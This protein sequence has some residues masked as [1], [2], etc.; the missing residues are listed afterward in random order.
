MGGGATGDRIF[1]ADDDRGLLRL[2]ARALEREG[3]ATATAVSGQQALAWLTQNQARLM[4]LD[5]KLPDVEGRELIAR[6]QAAGR[7]PAFI[8][9]TG[10]GD[11]RVAVEMMKRGALDYL[12]KDV[13]FLQFVP[14]VVKRALEQLD[15]E[16]RLAEAEEQVHLVRSVVDQGFSAVLITDAELPDPR[17]VY[18]N[19]TFAQVTGYA[20]ANVIG[21]RL[22]TLAGLTGVQEWL[23]AGLPEG[24]RFL[25]MVS[26][27]QTNAGE[28]WGEWRLGPV[29]DKSGKNAHWLIIFRDIT[30][31]KRLEKELLEISDREQQRI[32]QDL[33][34]GL[35]QHLAGIE[36]MSQVLEQ[37]L[38]RKSKADAVRAGEIG[39]L[40][41][42]AISQTRQVARGLS[43]VNLESGGLKSAL[44][45]LAANTEKRFGV[46]C[47]FVWQPLV[48]V[49]NPASATHLYR[50]AQ[51]AVSNALRHGKASRIRIELKAA[52]ENL[53]LS[54]CDNGKG[55][56]KALPPH[57]GMGLRIMQYRASLMGGSLRLQPEPGGGTGV[58]CSIPLEPGGTADTGT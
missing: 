56:P 25:E 57:K 23:R 27:Y 7:C 34:D 1:I 14:A 13:D 36:L 53:W 9:I 58:V 43:P 50:I 18:I 49:R 16:R 54:V 31:R 6:L 29:A 2:M 39:R 40:V 52:A 5:L 37:K 35:C 28:R 32:G 10:Q 41:R 26:S 33:H 17:I 4:L 48:R 24:E 30:E 42:D 55:M 11:E 20:P 19:P 8:I 47:E 51:E 12:V 3:F 45:E 46:V 21:Q 15:R 22:S 44:E 38:A